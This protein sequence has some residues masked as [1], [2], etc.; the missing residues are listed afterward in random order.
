M[1]VVRDSKDGQDSRRQA[2]DAR[3]EYKAVCEKRSYPHAKAELAKYQLPHRLPEALTPGL[4]LDLLGALLLLELGER[5]AQGACDSVV[6][7]YHAQ[8][9]GR[10]PEQRDI[11]C[12]YPLGYISSGALGDQ[13]DN[14]EDQVK[15]AHKRS[16]GG[17]PL[18][19]APVT[20][21]DILW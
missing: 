20:F 18:L 13:E 10:H 14:A 17:E 9:V 11:L 7:P 19:V 2:G 12:V 15:D 4:L 16:V 8:L 3:H 5:G 6:S 21:D 1:E